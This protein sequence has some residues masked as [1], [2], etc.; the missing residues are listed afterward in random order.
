MPVDQIRNKE[1]QDLMVI[2]C[3]HDMHLV[4]YRLRGGTVMNN[5]AVIESE[6]FKRGVK[7]YG[8][9]DELESIFPRAVPEVRDMLQY[10]S[11]E[12][13]WLL[14]D[15]EPVLNW[16]RGRSTLLGD[17]AHPTLQYLAQGACM[18]IEDA[19]VLAGKVGSGPVDFNAAFI[20]YQEERAL[21]TAR[22]VLT[23]RVFGGLCHAGGAARALRNEIA[24]RHTP[25][26]FWEYDWLYKGIEVPRQ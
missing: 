23:S 9:P 2:W 26:T 15:R 7:D 24:S 18:A 10:V 16:T 19:V 25:H 13:N 5:V 12:R 1:Y 11:R 3:G 6:Q 8:G 22:V 20:A 4:Q 14:H 21:R 17:A